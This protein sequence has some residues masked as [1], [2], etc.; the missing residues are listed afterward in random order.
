M[1][2]LD[3]MR[4]AQT[5]L[6]GVAVETDLLISS[7]TGEIRARSFPGAWRLRSRP[8]SHAAAL[9]RCCRR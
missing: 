4:A 8:V 2:S 6:A 9:S 7:I 5:R 3:D 1:I